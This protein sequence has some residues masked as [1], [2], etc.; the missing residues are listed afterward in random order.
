MSFQVLRHAHALSS[1]VAS[2]NFVS[3]QLLRRGFAS[4]ISCTA[5]HAGNFTRRR[6]ECGDFPNDAL[7]ELAHTQDYPQAFAIDPTSLQLMVD[8][9]MQNVWTSLTNTPFDP[10]QHFTSAKSRF[11]PDIDGFR[12]I[13]VRESDVY[14]VLIHPNSRLKS[15][16]CSVARRRWN[17]IC[18]AR[19][20]GGH[21]RG[22]RIHPC[23]SR[24]DEACS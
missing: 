14:R 23:Q 18:A 4:G 13:E 10:V 9:A 5:L 16:V 20:P 21:A 8:P 6:R 17:G 3:P 1:S 15:S 24:L 19:L 11:T 12:S 22:N 2:L 7:A